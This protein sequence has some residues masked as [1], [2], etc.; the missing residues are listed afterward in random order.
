MIK[1]RCEEQ[2][3][4]TVD[5]KDDKKEPLLRRM[6]A[7][8]PPK[9][10]RSIMEISPDRIKY[11]RGLA[12]H[13]LSVKIRK[14]SLIHEKDPFVIYAVEIFTPF[15]RQIE[16]K[17]YTSFIELQHLVSLSSFTAPSLLLR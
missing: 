16:V 14:H 12:Q 10:R 9:P 8:P 11:M 17:R 4:P 1:G 2:I 5:E 13:H 15:S 6:L 7:P 3:E